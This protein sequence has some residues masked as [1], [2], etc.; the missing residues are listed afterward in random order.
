MIA[1]TGIHENTLVIRCA[2]QRKVQLLAK[3]S[4]RLVNSY[5]VILLLIIIYYYYK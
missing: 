2:M 1:V 5:F 4:F 3:F